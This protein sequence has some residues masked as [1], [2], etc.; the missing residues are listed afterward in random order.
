MAFSMDIFTK[1]RTPEQFF[2]TQR[3]LSHGFLTLCVM[4]L[5]LLFILSDKFC[6]KVSSSSFIS[7]EKKVSDQIKKVEK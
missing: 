7:E 4:R 5:D 3:A 1:S 2:L 6:F